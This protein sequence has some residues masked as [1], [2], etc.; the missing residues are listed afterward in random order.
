M[1]SYWHYDQKIRNS[2]ISEDSTLYWDISYSLIM[3]FWTLGCL[4]EVYNCDQSLEYSEFRYVVR[5]S[6][7]DSE[8]LNKGEWNS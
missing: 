6:I 4:L 5:L 7:S 1:T 8:T 3:I 2:W